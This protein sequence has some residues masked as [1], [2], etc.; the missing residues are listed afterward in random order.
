[1]ILI[2][3]DHLSVLAEAR[4]KGHEELKSRLQR[5]AEP[6]AVTV[7]SLEEQMRGWLALIHRRKDIHEQV[8]AYDRLV[9]LV[10][11]F[12]EWDIVRLDDRAADRFKALKRERL[13]IGTMD[14]KIAS[15]ALVHDALLLSANLRDFSRIPGLMV[16]DWLSAA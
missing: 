10:E 15:I 8:H 2:D 9:R 7:V 14:L 4:T 5:A 11:F 12:G 3:T 16:Q 13:K 6:C 1:M